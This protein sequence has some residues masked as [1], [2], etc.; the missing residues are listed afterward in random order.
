MSKIEQAQALIESAKRLEAVADPWSSNPEI[1]LQQRRRREEQ[2]LGMRMEA[3][4]L[5]L[6]AQLEADQ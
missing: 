5:A 2:A 3:V 6:A 4:V 1:N